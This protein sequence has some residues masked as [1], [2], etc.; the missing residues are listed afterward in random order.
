MGKGKTL[1]LTYFAYRKYLQGLDIYAN[2]HLNFP[3]FP[4]GHHQPKIIYVRSVQDVMRMKN[5]YF[6]GDENEGEKNFP[7]SFALGKYGFQ[8]FGN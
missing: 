7:L 5:G 8:I 2:Y 4:E 6:A 1:A 3:K